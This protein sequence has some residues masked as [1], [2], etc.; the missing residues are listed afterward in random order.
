MQGHPDLKK[1]LQ[2]STRFCLLGFGLLTAW[3]E[4]VLE[5]EKTEWRR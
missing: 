4:A 3:V 2:G 5:G 1:L